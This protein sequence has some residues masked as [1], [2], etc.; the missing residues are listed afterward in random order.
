MLEAS[1]RGD[2]MLRAVYIWKRPHYQ[3]TRVCD[4]VISADVS[5]A[6]GNAKRVCQ[7]LLEAV[8]LDA[9]AFRDG[10]L[11]SCDDAYTQACMVVHRLSLLLVRMLD[12]RGFHG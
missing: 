2:V 6:K 8:G 7:L 3:P 9:R 12:G 10:N 5:G 11:D 1:V 4:L